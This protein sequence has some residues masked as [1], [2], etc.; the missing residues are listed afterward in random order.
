[1]GLPV[2][3]GGGAGSGGAASGGGAP[4]ASAPAAAPTAAP[5]GAYSGAP[6]ATS[7]AAAAPAQYATPQAAPAQDTAAGEYYS[8][9][10]AY[11]P[12]D[13]FEL[14]FPAGATIRVFSKEDPDWWQGQVMGDPRTGQVPSNY[15]KPAER[16]AAAQ[17][18][19]A[20]STPGYSSVEAAGGGA[21][22][23]AQLAGYGWFHGKMGRD[24]AEKTLLAASEGDG[25]FLMRESDNRPGTYTL[26]VKFGDKVSHFKID[27]QYEVNGRFFES[28]PAIVEAYEASPIVSKSG[29]NTRLLY[30]CPKL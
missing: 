25:T 13:E 2:G 7:A 16:G 19:Q 8:A 26:S 29:V 28:L 21:D 6:A 1:M 24:Q 23:N 3:G 4:A 10:Y 22:L 11:T 30:P 9:I 12:Q 5:A 15:L 18:A 17:Y 20:Q 27:G 14:G